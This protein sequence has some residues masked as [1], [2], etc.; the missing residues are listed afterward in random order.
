MRRRAL[1][2]GT[3]LEDSCGHSTCDRLPAG[4]RYMSALT[5]LVQSRQTRNS[6]TGPAQTL[7][8]EQQ[9]VVMSG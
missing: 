2:A 5:S 7:S 9:S 6:Q 4:R 3:H 8:Q 1:E